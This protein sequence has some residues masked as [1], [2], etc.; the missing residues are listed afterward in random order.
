MAMASNG[1]DLVS[2]LLEDHQAVKQL[3]G[4][5]DAVRASRAGGSQGELFCELT[6]ELV[7]HEVAEEEVLYPA[8]RSVL[9]NGG[10]LADA[11]IGEQS[12]A[13]ETLAEMEKLDPG[14]ATFSAKL[15]ELRSDVLAHAEREEREVFAPLRSSLDLAHLESLGM[16]YEMAKAVAPSH[17]HPHA[18]D[19]PPGNLVLGPVAA[20]FDR[21]RDAI[22]TA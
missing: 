10:P 17:P 21:V 8:V 9:P 4:R 7:R 15:T 6:Y 13:E 5:F 12:E 2:A 14:S 1:P 20:L 3:F 18:P 19:T 22:R 16:R 11:R